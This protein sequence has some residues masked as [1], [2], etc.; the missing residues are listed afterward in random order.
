[1]SPSKQITRQLDVLRTLV[2][3]RYGATLDDL[4]R[5]FGVTV[6]TVQRDI[7]DL[8]EAGFPLYD[9][10]RE[11]RTVWRLAREQQLPVNFPMPEVLALVA[12]Q[13]AMESMAGGP[14]QDDLKAALRRNGRMAPILRS[15][16]WVVCARQAADTNSSTKPEGSPGL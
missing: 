8:C 5:E 1:M 4:S 6:R 3:R 7:E 10:R 2:A 16:L 14:F 11:G 13:R 9:E 15:R 12:A